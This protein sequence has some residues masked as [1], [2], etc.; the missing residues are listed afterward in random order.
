MKNLMTQKFILG[1]LMML[2]LAFGVQ[3]VVD[4]VEDPGLEQSID[5]VI[6]LHRVHSTFSNAELSFIFDKAGTKETVKISKSSGIDL[7]GTFYDRSSVT[8][9]EE[10][11]V[12]AN[13]KADPQVVAENGDMFTYASDA[14][15]IAPTRITVSGRFTKKG[16]QTVTIS[17]TD[18]DGTDA[19]KWSYT[20]VYYVTEVPISKTATVSFVGLRNGYSIGDFGDADILIHKGDSSHYPVTYTD[21]AVL[22]IKH[23]AGE[24]DVPITPISSAFDVY[25]N[26]D[27]ST[28]TVT[29]EVGGSEVS[30]VGVYIYGFPTLTVTE[31]TAQGSEGTPGRPGEKIVNAFEATVQDGVPGIVEGVVVTFT[32]KGSGTAG[33][34]LIFD[35]SNTGSNTGT[36]VGSNHLEML[37]PNNEVITTSRTG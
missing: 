37:N 15:S 18:S 13:S 1:L 25:L 14:A 31:P 5:D 10:G 33:G 35:G 19:G 9:T 3:G 29:A 24:I 21:N 34:E 4:A 30:T 23:S 7:I 6:T 20:Y 17:G 36:L 32:A 27:S 28:D 22:M 26:A 12:K 16:K 8:L 11:D 2:V